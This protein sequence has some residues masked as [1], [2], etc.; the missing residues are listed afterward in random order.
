MQEISKFVTAY[1]AKNMGGQYA[2]AGGIKGRIKDLESK[3]DRAIAHVNIY[4][5]RELEK[6]KNVHCDLHS[7]VLVLVHRLFLLKHTC[8][9]L[10]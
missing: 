5:S 4:L 2:F 10:R 3:F 7:E 8:F 1:D 9:G 6:V